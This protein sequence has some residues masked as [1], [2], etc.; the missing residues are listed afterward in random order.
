MPLRMNSGTASTV[1]SHCILSGVR[2]TTCVEAA[3]P[4]VAL[5]AS[6]SAIA[7]NRGCAYTSATVTSGWRRRSSDTS[8]S[9]ASEPPPRSKK[10]SSGPPAG[11]PSTLR[12]SAARAAETGSAADVSASAS[13]S[14]G[15]GNAA[16]I[17]DGDFN[18]LVDAA[19]GGIPEALLRDQGVT[20][21]DHVIISHADRD[22]V[23]GLPS[24]LRQF[25]VKNVWVNGDSS[26]AGRTWDAVRAAVWLSEQTH[27]SVVRNAVAAG[28]DILS[29]TGRVEIKVLAPTGG[30]MLWGAGS[31]PPGRAKQTSNSLSAVV[32][33]FVDAKASVLLAG[34]AGGQAL[35]VMEARGAD[36]R[37]P[38]LIFPHHG[39]RPGRDDPVGV[40]QAY[41]A[42]TEPE[43]VIFS[44]GRNKPGFPRPDVVSAVRS[45]KPSAHVAC[46]QLNVEC[47][48]ATPADV[49]PHLAALPAGGK[50]SRSCCAGTIE[51]V[52]GA[53]LGQ[54]VTPALAEH[55]AF[56]DSLG[57]VPICRRSV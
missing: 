30:S 6:A 11:I 32:A 8:F 55:A 28:T 51:Y 43:Q 23:G 33:V 20:S 4:D 34:D 5:S 35:S 17:R 48:A 54:A 24:I 31:A 12:Q 3:E 2:G 36:L 25:H 19:P 39:G 46:T 45:A 44:V 26:R 14:I 49:P 21:V 57:G 10:L 15:H 9:A 53:T 16:L 18:V 52:F 47:A 27:G 56:V 40:A 13:S 38:V 7:P 22:H 42:A 29:P 41:T 1:C 37:T 50:G